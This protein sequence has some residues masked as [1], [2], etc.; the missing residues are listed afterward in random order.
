MPVEIRSGI[1][2][3]LFSFVMLA[4]ENRVSSFITISVDSQISRVPKDWRFLS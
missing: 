1:C 4:G 3:G 2:T